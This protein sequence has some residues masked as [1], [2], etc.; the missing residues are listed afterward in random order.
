MDNVL[1]DG[2]LAQELR[3]VCKRQH[4]ETVMLKRKVCVQRMIVQI[5]LC[6]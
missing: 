1:E 2:P 3:M 5:A 6:S 4:K